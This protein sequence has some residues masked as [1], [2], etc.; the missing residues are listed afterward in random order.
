MDHTKNTEI[1]ER[2]C[3]CIPGAVMSNF[4]KEE[5]QQPVF[6]KE[7][8]GARVYDYDG[9]EY[10]DFGLSFGPAIL[11]RENEHVKNAV[12]EQV[13]KY[14]TNEMS[15]LQIEAAEK[16]QKLI[17][18]VELVRFSCS[19]TEA[20]M[21]NVRIARGYTGKNMLVKFNGQYNGGADFVLGGL[22]TD[23]ENPVAKD[24]INY[25]D[26]YSIL[27]G[28]DGRAAHALEDCYM[29][30]WNDLD[31]LEKLFKKDADNIAAVI[32]EPVM[33]NINGCVP[34][35]GYLEGVR[36]LCTKYNVV[37]IFDEVLT[38]FRMGLQ[39]AQGHFG[40]T[41]D[42]TTF[43]KAV[44]S[45]IPVSV[46][47]GKKEIMD[48]LSKTEVISGG[49]YNGHPL[50]MA[51]LIATLEELEKDDCAV[52]KHIERLGN[53]LR[54]GMLEIADKV[55]CKTLRVQGYP[56]AWNVLFSE[57]DKIINHKDGMENADLLKLSVF[58]GLLKE[59]GVITTLR[60]CTGAAHTEE[61]IKETLVRF[62]EALIEFM[63]MEM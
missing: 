28:T 51:G 52:F 23:K 21:N 7:V 10:I 4:K 29:I 8:K 15:L 6:I 45:G 14:Y 54:D 12:I 31:A 49:T 56:A 55:G 34:E 35:P 50:A 19:G 9:N 61:D 27:C 42:L 24:E 37:L 30:E 1:Y 33:T 47:C 36:E 58:L 38:G 62:E 60:F 41:P 40:I 39:G 57:K 3:K 63:N 13:K 48:V 26:L 11:G 43:A 5:G 44:G 18:S 22:A 32:M 20:N 53:M 17:P 16:I 59:K 2:G 25:E 46:F